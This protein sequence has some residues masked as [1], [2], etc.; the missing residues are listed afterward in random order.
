MSF[1]HHYRVVRGSQNSRSRN[2][3][4]RK[5]RARGAR[6]DLGGRAP[7]RQHGCGVSCAAQDL[8]RPWSRNT[9]QRST[10]TC[11]KSRAPA[12]PPPR[13]PSARSAVVGEAASLFL[14]R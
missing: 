9:T 13:T 1:C 4:S 11:K 10:C 7:A 14:V 5:S 3:R 2:L 12:E 6:D 8:A